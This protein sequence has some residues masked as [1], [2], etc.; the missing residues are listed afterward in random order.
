MVFFGKGASPARANSNYLSSKFDCHV[1]EQG[2]GVWDGCRLIA[3]DRISHATC[4][5]GLAPG[6][7]S[8]LCSAIDCA[9]SIKGPRNGSDKMFV[10]AKTAWRRFLRQRTIR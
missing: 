4:C 9:F 10:R 8:V 5:S 3:H 1:P 6:R 2:F 7:N